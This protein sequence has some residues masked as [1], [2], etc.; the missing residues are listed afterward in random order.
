MQESRDVLQCYTPFVLSVRT[1]TYV[2]AGMW[3]KAMR[4]ILCYAAVPM[5]VYRVD[6]T[7]TEGY[8]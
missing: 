4:S 5:Q 8:H 3:I 1:A 6:S 2:A 7:G